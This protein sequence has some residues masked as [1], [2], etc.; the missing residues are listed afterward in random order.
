VLA[1]GTLACIGL[2]GCMTSTPSWDQHRGEALAAV[3]QQQI[4]NPDAPTGLPTM[5]GT[6]GKTAVAAMRN[7]DR[8]QIRVQTRRAAPSVVSASTSARAGMAAWVWAAAAN[9]KQTAGAPSCPQPGLAA[10]HCLAFTRGSAAP[11]PSSSAS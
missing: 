1:F 10:C 6:D 8:S 11:L 3:K 9:A 5:D 2:S 7:F 4:I